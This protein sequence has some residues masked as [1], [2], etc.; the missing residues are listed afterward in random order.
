MMS[1]DQPLKSLVSPHA[2]FPL[3]WNIY[4]RVIQHKFIN[5]N[6]I[7]F[8]TATFQVSMSGWR[9]VWEN[10]E[11]IYIQSRLCITHLYKLE[12]FVDF[13][14]T[15]PKSWWLSASE[16]FL[17]L[18]FVAL[19][20]K[21]LRNKKEMEEKCEMLHIFYEEKTNKHWR[22]VYESTRTVLARMERFDDFH[23]KLVLT[24]CVFIDNE[25]KNVNLYENANLWNNKNNSHQLSLEVSISVV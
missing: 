11:F 25:T 19:W 14:K 18:A 2:F 15:W 7:D 6:F 17:T 23:S 10:N 5:S 1:L 12:C 16:C 8:S 4:E 20:R 9:A 3:R 13:V 22:I 21:Y 24:E